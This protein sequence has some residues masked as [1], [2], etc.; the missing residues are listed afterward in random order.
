MALSEKTIQR[1]VAGAKRHGWPMTEEEIRAQLR[2]GIDGHLVVSDLK[3]GEELRSG[4][5][6]FRCLTPVEIRR[7]MGM[8]GGK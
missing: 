7:A 6:I 1:I 2:N 5:V 8:G 4:S 3:P